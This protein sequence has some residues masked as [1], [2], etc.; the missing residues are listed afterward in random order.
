[1]ATGQNS[2]RTV[3]N[4]RSLLLVFLLTTISPPFSASFE[5]SDPSWF[6]TT[7]DLS[8]SSSSASIFDLANAQTYPTGDKWNF[9]QDSSTLD[10][11]FLEASCSNRAD[12]TNLSF[13][14]KVRARA[15]D[16]GNTCPKGTANP[17]GPGVSGGDDLD[18]MYDSVADSDPEFPILV[19][20]DVM[21]AGLS[22]NLCGK[23]NLVPMYAVCD[24]GNLVDRS[25]SLIYLS[26][27]YTTYKLDNCQVCTFRL[28]LLLLHLLLFHSSL[29]SLTPLP[30]RSK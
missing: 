2:P 1:M 7:E 5:S 6:E 27:F 15:R 26:P 21:R 23:Y 16:T 12:E 11:S 13:T 19:F 9:D 17:G 3:P 30:G 28:L 10:L 25:I 4:M 22:P 24:S 29:S 18:D 14:A 20:P 8:S